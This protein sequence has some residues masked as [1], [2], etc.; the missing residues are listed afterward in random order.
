VVEAGETGNTFIDGGELPIYQPVDWL[1]D[2][3]PLQRPL[4]WWADL[5]RV[6]DVFLYSQFRR[7]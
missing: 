6:E 5:W 2:N 3:T 4:F 7:D 1:I